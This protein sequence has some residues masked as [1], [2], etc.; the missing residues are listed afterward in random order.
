MA[1]KSSFIIQVQ[2]HQ[3]LINKILFLYA[4]NEEDKKDLRQEILAQ[5]W[6]SFENFRGEARFSTWLYRIGLN[7]AIS[8][9]RKNRRVS[10]ADFK[11]FTS[12]SDQSD[13]ELLEVILGVLNPVEKSVVLLL[14]DGFK[15]DEIAEMLG[16]STTNTRVKIHR[17]REKLRQNGIEE[18][19]G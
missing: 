8:H 17:L 16:I 9:L 1:D 3:K 11:T 2:D 14:V 18:F 5:A 4:D 7:V 15:Q 19:I 13:K 10:E 12:H 6:R